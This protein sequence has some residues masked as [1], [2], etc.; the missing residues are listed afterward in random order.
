MH[1]FKYNQYAHLMSFAVIFKSTRTEDSTDLYHEQTELMEAL[2]KSIPGYLSHFSFRDPATREGVT[3]SYFESEDAIKKW[4]QVGEH[5]R[6]QELGR[7]DFYENYEVQ[8]VEILREY[9]WN[10]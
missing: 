2:V 9:S 4:K 6:A 10:K 3:I 5:I 8:V 1:L 7:S